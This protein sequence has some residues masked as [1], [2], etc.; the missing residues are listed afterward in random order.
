MCPTHGMV[1][2]HRVQRSARSATGY[3]RHPVAL[4]S[5][6]PTTT[7]VRDGPDHAAPRTPPVGFAA[8][9]DAAAA[10]S[11]RP[12]RV[13]AAND[14]DLIVAGVASM[15]AAYPDR[16]EVR[17]R[18]LVGDPIRHGPIDVVL[19]DTY[20]RRGI[21]AEALGELVAL[22]E[23]AHVALFSL[24]LSPALIADAQAAGASGVISKSLSGDAVCDAIER[25]ADG[26]QVVALADEADETDEA[27]RCQL[28]WPGRDDGLSERESQV[29][30]LLAEGLHNKEIATALY[31]SVETVKTHVRQ[32]L[33]K[34]GVRNRV[35]ATA[36]VLRTGAF[37]RYRP[38][39]PDD[40]WRSPPGE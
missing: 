28:D 39:D 36:Y 27:V 16:V 2:G 12:V 24:D 38:A 3:P 9:G 26:E 17:D 15:L 19:Y 14:Y 34:L 5:A 11:R 29:L 35:E 30:V 33:A 4:H 40:A 37:S 23:V 31:L 20:G 25:I 18:V 1:E 8:V 21:A 32:V 13:A 6:S 7:R 10:S 22:P